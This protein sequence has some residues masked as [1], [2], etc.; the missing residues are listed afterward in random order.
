MTKDK[1]RSDVAASFSPR[2][3]SMPSYRLV[4][5][6]LE[7]GAS[8]GNSA[9]W[10]TTKSTGAIERIF[11]IECGKNV[12]GS[13]SVQYGGTG[14][15][16]RTEP[17]MI[18]HASTGARFIGLDRDGPADV[19]I[20][21]VYQRRRFTLGGAI[22]VTETLFVP[23]GSG[24]DDAP[25]AYLSVD[26]QCMDSGPHELRVMCYARL[27][28]SPGDDIDARYEPRLKALVARNTRVPETVRIFGLSV[29]PTGFATTTD[30]GS[31]SDRSHVNAVANDTSARKRKLA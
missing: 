24:M 9:I 14:S 6:D 5:T 17:D 22:A 26:V 8:L 4:E 13:V 11:N 28:G 29:K 27:G 7:M 1:Q 25:V 20:H 16:L 31:V 15:S 3:R 10:L 21:P 18:G 30:Y 12:V 2:Q 23:L 19:E